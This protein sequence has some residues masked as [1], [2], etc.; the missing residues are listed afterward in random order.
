MKKILFAILAVIVLAVSSS[1]CIDVHLGKEIFGGSGAI[2]PA[3]NS[4]TVFKEN[5]SY[6]FASAPTA[7]L[8]KHTDS[9]N[10]TVVEG[11]FRMMIDI[12][13]TIQPSSGFEEAPTFG[14]RYVTVTIILP[15]GETYP[16]GEDGERNYTDSAH[17][18]IIIENPISGSWSVNVEGQGIGGSFQDRSFTDS[19][20]I[21]IFAEEPI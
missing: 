17:D 6:V 21:Q 11:C 9:C 8:D 10:V 5:L 4:K 13:V 2:K 1:G 15:S 18:T 19:Y 12:T 20:S 3:I 7:P 14:M 16:D